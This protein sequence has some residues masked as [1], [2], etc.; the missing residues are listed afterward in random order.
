M[1]SI[2]LAHLEHDA[3]EPCICLVKSLLQGIVEMNVQLFVVSQIAADSR[4]QPV[5]VKLFCS[6][7]VEVRGENVDS[8]SHGLRSPFFR[9]GEF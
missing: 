7:W 5:P 8:L 6:N 2:F 9:P 3:L 4:N 1:K